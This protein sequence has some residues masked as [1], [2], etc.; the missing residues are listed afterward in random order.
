MPKISG[1]YLQ[2]GEGRRKDRVQGKEN[3]Y[4]TGVY[5]FDLQD[6]HTVGRLFNRVT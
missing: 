6:D 3:Q 1:L 4:I 5:C 2:G